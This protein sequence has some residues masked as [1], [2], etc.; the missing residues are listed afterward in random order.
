MAELVDSQVAWN[1]GSYRKIDGKVVSAGCSRLRRKSWDQ[2]EA[3]LVQDLHTSLQ[4]V[5]R[6]PELSHMYGYDV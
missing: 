3:S 6:K 5:S 1:R 2:C 4:T